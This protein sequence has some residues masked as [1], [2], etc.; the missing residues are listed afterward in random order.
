[1]NSHEE[2]SDARVGNSS[3]NV[4]IKE[5]LNFK[6]KLINFKCLYLRCYCDLSE[7]MKVPESSYVLVSMCVIRYGIGML[8]LQIFG[9]GR[10]E[11]FKNSFEN[12]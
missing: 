8:Q 4:E 3:Q 9:N 11:N 2:W 12:V 5:S 6:R 1:M 7:Q 10:I